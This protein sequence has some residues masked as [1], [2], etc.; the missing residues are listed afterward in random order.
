MNIQKLVTDAR[1]GGFALW[2]LNFVL[3]RGIPFNKPHNI[4]IAEIGDN[5]VKVT[6]PYKRK[7]LNHIKGIHACGLATACE[8]ASGFVLLNRLGAKKYRIIMESIEVKY[9][10]QAKKP[11]IASFSISEAELESKVLKPL[12]TE[13]KILIRCEILCHDSDGNHLC[14]GYTNW[15]IKSWDKVK[16]KA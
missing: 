5:A 16:T 4:R 9:L 11:A 10:Y 3:Q 6:I 12:E 15:Q 13:E 2:K 1:K 8:Y 7:N 14:T